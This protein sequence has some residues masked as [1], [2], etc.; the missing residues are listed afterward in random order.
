MDKVMHSVGFSNKVVVNAKGT[1]GGLCLMWK[2]SLSV[3]LVDFNND[4]I[5]VKIYDV[6]C[7]WIFV[8]FYGPSYVAKKKKAWENLLALFESFEIPS[9]CLGDFNFTT[10]EDEKLGGKKGSSSHANYLQEL[11]FEFDAIDL[12]FSGNKFTWAKRRR[13]KSTIKRRLDRAIASISW[14]LCNKQEDTRKALRTWNKEVFG[15]CQNRINTLIQEIKSIQEGDNSED[16]GILEGKLQAELAEWLT[17]SEI[18]WRQKSREL[19]LKHG[20]KNSKFFH[21]ST[22]IQRRRNNIDSI[23]TENGSWISETSHIQNHF[24]NGFKS[25]FFAETTSFPT[26]LENLITPDLKAAGP[27]GFPILF[28]KKYWPIVGEVVTKAVTSFFLYGS[29]PKE[30]NSSLIVLIPKSQNPTSFNNFRPI[31]LCNVVY[32]IISKI[33]VTKLSPL[34]HNL[35]SPHQSAFLQGRWI[36]ENQIIVQEMMHSFKTR[37][38]KMGLMAIKLDLQKAYDRVNWDFLKTMLVRFDFNDTFIGWIMACISSV[39]FEDLVNGGKTKQFKSSRGFQQGDPFSPYLFILGQK[40]LSRMIEQEPTIKGVKASID[41]PAITHV[42]Y[43]DDI[44]LFPKAT[45]RDATKI[46]ECLDKYCSW[47]GQKLNRNKYGIFFSKLTHSLSRRPI[48]QV[49]QMKSLK[50]DAIYLGAPLFLSS[51]PSKDFKFLQDRLEAQLS[52]WRSKCLSWAGRC[53]LINSVAQTLPTYAMSIFNIPSKICDSLDATLRRFWWKPKAQDGRFLTLKAWDKLCLP[54]GKSGLGFKKAKDANRA[55]LAKLAW[56]VASKRDSLCMMI[57]RA[58]YKVRHDWL[59][60]EP[61]KAVSPIWK[62]IEGVKNIIVRGSYY[63]I[64]NGADISVW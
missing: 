59:Y 1:V 19:W 44:I 14:R 25:L 17:R 41:G 10:N 43:A 18:L 16:H 20:D 35:I 34:L 33:L 47:L 13:G 39:H 3:D 21:L 29:M 55:L 61:V 37:K 6:V 15:K 52:S 58:K 49:L 26:N 8:G 12:G 54:K 36:T 40:V 53:T 48:K 31:S 62:A 22:I 27:N 30:V 38:V 56:M 50:Q 23:K 57:L 64:G 46:N 42:M 7:E 32:K 24:L 2:S 5:A 51:T 11:M 28:Y 63:L 9:V 60:K 45:R 4:I